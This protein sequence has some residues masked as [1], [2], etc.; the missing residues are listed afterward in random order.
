MLVGYKW[1]N[2]AWRSDAV[3]TFRPLTPPP[4]SLTTFG[5]MDT[6]PPLR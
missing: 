1:C 4:H 2:G 5:V 6:P 3:L